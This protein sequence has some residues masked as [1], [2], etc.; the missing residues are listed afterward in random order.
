M[1]STVYKVIQELDTEDGVSVNIQITK[2]EEV[3]GTNDC[4]VDKLRSKL[5]LVLPSGY[6]VIELED[7]IRLEGFDL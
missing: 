3:I 6:S 2:T 7:A 1:I 5:L 4:Y